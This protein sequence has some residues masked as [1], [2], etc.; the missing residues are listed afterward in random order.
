[1]A[2]KIVITPEDL[3]DPRIDEVL[4]RERAIREVAARARPVGGFR[5]F[6]F[7]SMFYLAI[8]GALGG[9]LGWAALEPYVDDGLP[10]SGAIT[11]IEPDRTLI[12][13]PRCEILYDGDAA[14]PGDA[15]EHCKGALVESPFRGAFQLA[16][17][18][19]LVAPGQTRLRRDGQRGRLGDVNDLRV[20]DRVF[21]VGQGIENKPTEVLAMEVR[22]LAAGEAGPGE[23]DLARRSRT[24]RYAGLAWFALIGGLIAF[25]VGS[26]EGL[27]SFN[28]GQALKSGLIGLAIGFGGGLAGIVPA[29]LLYSVAGDLTRS[30]ARGQGGFL[31]A[32]D[33]HGWALFSQ[34]VSR[35]LAWGI[36]G[37]ALAL[38]RG[39]AM[40]SRKLIL[41]GLIGGCLG[42]LFGGMLFDPIGRLGAADTGDLSRAVGFTTIGLLVGFCLGLVEQLSK[43][44]WLLMRTGPLQGKQ[45]VVHRNPTTI[46]GLGHCDIFLFKDAR[47]RAEHARLNR[48]G[49][50]YEIED[51]DTP[52]GTFVNGVRVHRR[53][54]RDG[55]TITIG[56]TELEYRSRGG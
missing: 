14:R 18:T 54:L 36:V 24:E 31:T 39:V 17:T 12:E 10:I 25:G 38:G 49:R 1:M 30:L 15:C 16:K 2:G 56:S 5:K 4:D 32:E 11:R 51:L 7:S 55:D 53:I 22:P 48:V 20:G 40:K 8:V 29:G 6:F 45:F 41:N 33:L 44:A 28:A 43:E 23:P 34:I 47:V 3:R 42:G 21:V 46:G 37:M 35:S 27:L 13:C 50:A 26:V 52:E 9:F 19:V